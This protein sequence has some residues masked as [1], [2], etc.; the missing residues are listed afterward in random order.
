[1]PLV[2]VVLPIAAAGMGALVAMFVSA[3]FVAGEDLK[4]GT[5]VV[6]YLGTIL[7]SALLFAVLG[8]KMH[9]RWCG[10]P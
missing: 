1:M 7:G 8:A 3:P 6:A 5:A 10:K 4:T 9:R 2:P